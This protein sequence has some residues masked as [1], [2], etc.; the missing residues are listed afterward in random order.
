MNNLTI[1]FFLITLI[2]YTTVSADTIYKYK[3]KDGN[4]V[5]GDLKPS[6]AKEVKKLNFKSTEKPSKKIKFIISKDNKTNHLKV[7]NPFH[8]PIE[9]K[10]MMQGNS[11]KHLIPASSTHVVY[12]SKK[13]IPKYNYRFKLGDPKAQADNYRYLFP[14]HSRNSFKISQSF[15]G[16]FSHYREPNIYAV[17]IPM[18]VGTFI[19]AARGGT[20]IWV[21]DDYHIKGQKSYFLNKANYVK[22]LHDDGTYAVYAHIMNSLVKPGEE[23]QAGK[24]IARSGYSGYSTGPHL[25]F[26]IRR[27]AGFKTVSVPFVFVDKKGNSFTPQRGKLV[28]GQQ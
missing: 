20:V 8:A 16:R 14:V 27:N 9:L 12:K 15:N 11:T 28:K 18:D 17:D 10:L 5:F 6:S 1:I 19:S 25:H 22:I 3:D 23:I 21:K 4:W 13:R 26:V 24:I 2:S 7:H